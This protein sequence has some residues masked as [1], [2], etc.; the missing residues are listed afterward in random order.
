MAGEKILVVEDNEVNR[1]LVV[2]LL[3]IAGYLVLVA[4]T[5]EEGLQK[6]KEE[7]PDLI[8]MDIGLPGMDGLTATRILKQ[9]PETAHIAV[10]AL[11]SFAM[12]G[13]AERVKEAGCSGYLTKPIDT[14]TFAQT[15]AS[16]MVGTSKGN[17]IGGE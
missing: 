8:L 14:R 15:V 4:G 16:F 7:P 5:A 11:T 9:A 6:A 3:K 17:R 1:E 12:K 2:D 10:V 13:D